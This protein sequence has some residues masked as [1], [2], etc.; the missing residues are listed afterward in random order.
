M[1]RRHFLAASLAA[2]AFAIAPA[3]EAQSA[4]TRPR[5]FYQLRRYTLQTGPQIAMTEK[6][7]SEALIPAL[8]P[9]ER[10]P[11]GHFASISARRRRRST[12]SF[13]SMTPALGGNA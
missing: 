6:Y 5:E 9:R 8:A 4:I 12:S 13:R 7:I 3:A 10:D 2:S 1:D 11:L